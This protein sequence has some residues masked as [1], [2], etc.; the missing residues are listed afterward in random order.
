MEWE[1]QEPEFECSIRRCKRRSGWGMVMKQHIASG[2]ASVAHGP[3]RTTIAQWRW[4]MMLM[5]EVSWKGQWP[6]GVAV[7]SV[8]H[9][10]R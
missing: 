2:S 5:H 3:T 1:F 10:Y 8:F 9:H 4:C 6:Q 7:K